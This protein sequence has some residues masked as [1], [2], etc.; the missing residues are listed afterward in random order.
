MTFVDMIDKIQA[1]ACNMC[2]KWDHRFAVDELVNEA[3]IGS[4]S[5]ETEDA[6]LI[7]MRAKFDMIDY[8]RSHVGR[9]NKVKPIPKFLT[10]Y[11]SPADNQDYGRRN[12]FFDGEYEDKNLLSLENEELLGMIL[13]S[14][15]GRQLSIMKLY[16]F[17]AMTMN[18]VG[19][20][21]GIGESSVSNRIK[22][23]IQNC[24]LRISFIN[25]IYELQQQFGIADKE[26][27]YY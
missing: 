21:L 8:I 6:P 13:K 5:S 1:M 16:Y 27:I 17:E 9:T 18:D 3:W 12:S 23:G 20:E 19:E 14:P 22:N 15:T 24:Q 2:K 4:L 7:M 11:D 26:P 10:N 25:K